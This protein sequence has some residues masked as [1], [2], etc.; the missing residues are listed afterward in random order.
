[1]VYFDFLEGY[2]ARQAPSVSST[3][4]GDWGSCFLVGDGEEGSLWGVGEELVVPGAFEVADTQPGC[5][6][7]GVGLWGRCEKQEV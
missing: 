1:M 5:R 6:L 3:S 4:I 2:H 7:Q